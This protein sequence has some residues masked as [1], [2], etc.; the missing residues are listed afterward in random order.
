[1][2]NLTVLFL[3]FSLIHLN[4]QENYQL[5]PAHTFINFGVERFMVGEVTGR[6]T[7]FSGT[8]TYNKDD[9]SQLDIEVSIKVV[10]IDTGLEVRDGHLKSNIWLDALKYPEIHF[11]SK[12]VQVVD[13]QTIMTGDLSIHGVTQEI[14]FPFTFKGPFKDPTQSLTIGLAA[15]LTINRQDYGITFSRKMDNGHLFIGNEVK[16]NIRALGVATEVSKNTS[17]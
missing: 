3:L 5:D 10:S 4:A 14:T 6:F 17:K 8:I 15:D 11:K 16:L 7:D 12:K 2:K 9:L 13:N 1:M